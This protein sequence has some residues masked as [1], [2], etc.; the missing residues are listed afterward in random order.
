MQ[1]LFG[2]LVESVQ[3]IRATPHAAVCLSDES[4]L[5]KSRPHDFMFWN[6]S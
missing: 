2:Y 5:Q 6:K 1:I 3:R 4:N